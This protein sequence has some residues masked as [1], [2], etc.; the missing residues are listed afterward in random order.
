M[1]IIALSAALIYPRKVICEIEITKLFL[2]QLV[3]SIMTCRINRYDMPR[4]SAM[5][6]WTYT[7]T[8]LENKI[9]YNNYRY[10][11]VKLISQM[12]PLAGCDWHMPMVLSL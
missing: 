11:L 3:P 1:T 4:L 7:H 12:K 6:R 5:V 2:K 8:H 9:M 10:L